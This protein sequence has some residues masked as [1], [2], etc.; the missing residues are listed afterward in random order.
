MDKSTTD[1]QEFR[2]GT[3]WRPPASVA[4]VQKLQEIALRPTNIEALNFKGRLVNEASRVPA[5]SRNEVQQALATLPGDRPLWAEY[6]APKSRSQKVRARQKKAER[7][8]LQTQ[9]QANPFTNP[10]PPQTTTTLP[11]TTTTAADE[12][13][14][15]N[16]VMDPQEDTPMEEEGEVAEQVNQVTDDPMGDAGGSATATEPPSSSAQDDEV[17][18]EL[19]DI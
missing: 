5:D 18:F 17:D 15:S 10:A 7:E 2:Q 4:E 3:G 13:P 11:S 9:V 6:R 19:D 12:E 16:T 1:M 14:G 8:Q